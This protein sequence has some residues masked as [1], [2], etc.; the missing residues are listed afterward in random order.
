[1]LRYLL[2][3]ACCFASCSV[4]AADDPPVSLSVK[5]LAAKVKSSIV[6]ISH[7]G[8]EGSQAG[9]GTGFVIDKAAGLIATN[10]HVIGEARPIAVQTAEGKPLT[11][12]AVH[13]SDRALDLAVI[14]VEAQDLPA[15]ELGEVA[16][17]A[18]GEPV[19]MM[20]NPQGLKHS[21]VSGVLSGTR[22][23]DGRNML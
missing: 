22:E 1:M 16:M 6:V 19:V 13:A 23:I 7:G 12:K 5:E 9:L 15:L 4:V 10:L 21:V 17:L 20:G 3:A 14:Q 8:R 18:Q 11:V 2:F